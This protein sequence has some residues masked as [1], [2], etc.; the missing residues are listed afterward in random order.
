[1]MK[2]THSY[3]KVRTY[4]TYSTYD[5]LK[6]N[7]IEYVLPT[8]NLE[9]FCC[10]FFIFL[11]FYFIAVQFIISLMYSITHLSYSNYYCFFVF[12]F[13]SVFRHLIS[14]YFKYS[15]FFFFINVIY[16]LL[17]SLIQLFIT[18]LS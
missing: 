13:L 14:F 7:R 6:K 2:N 9:Y 17:F 18:P 10:F 11:L 12:L 16:S 1:M 5:H 4:N 8:H 15:I 3:N